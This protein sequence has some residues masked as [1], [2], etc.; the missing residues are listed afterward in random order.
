M[1]DVT[2]L[3]AIAQ[4]M[5]GLTNREASYRLQE[6]WPEIRAVGEEFCMTNS[7]IWRAAQQQVE[8][9]RREF[10]RVDRE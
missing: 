10:N 9:V 4:D 3:R 8:V 2:A 5:I 1:R 6:R 7:E